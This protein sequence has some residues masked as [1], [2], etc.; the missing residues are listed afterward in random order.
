[1]LYTADQNG[2]SRFVTMQNHYNLIYREEEREMMPLCLEEKVGLLSWSP[3]ARGFVMGNRRSSDFGETLRAKKDE[4]AHKLYYQPSDFTVVDRISEIANKKDVSNAQV[5]L[6]WVLAQPGVTAPI[7][8]A[9]KMEHL[10]DAVASLR[11]KLD[12]SELKLLAEPYVPHQ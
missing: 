4:Y 5:A 11:V 7:I 1:M 10:D 3:L 6:A 9:S 12:P 8:G 2:L